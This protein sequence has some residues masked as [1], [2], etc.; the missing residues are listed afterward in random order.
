MTPPHVI[1]S[2]E[3]ESV[4]PNGVQSWV[5]QIAYL[6]VPSVIS[7][8]LVWILANNIRADVSDIKAVAVRTDLAIAT[9]A[10]ASERQLEKVT[11][12]L[13]QICVNGA[14]TEDARDRCF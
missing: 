2:D 6:G 13:Q 12:I 8:G 7:L 11:R 4:M 9:H 14:R 5:K 10:A 1:L 3:P